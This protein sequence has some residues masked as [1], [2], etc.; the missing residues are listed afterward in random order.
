MARLVRVD[1]TTS[2]IDVARGLAD[3]GAE[4]FTVVLADRQTAGRGRRGCTWMTIPGKSL[5]ATA[6]VR[7]LP[8][9]D[10]LGLAG[11]AAALA[12]VRA[13]RRLHEL[14]LRTKW[15]NDVLAEKRDSPHFLETRHSQRLL[16]KGVCPL[17]CPLF[18]GKV[19]GTLAEVRGS[20]LLLS[21]GLNINGTTAD[22]PS[23]LRATATTLE[24]AVGRPLDRDAVAEG[25]V[26]ELE[27]VWRTLLT[28]PGDLIAE[29]ETLDVTRGRQVTVTDASD[30][31][32]TGRALG[33]DAR[34]CLRLLTAEGEV[35]LSAGDVT[36]TE[37]TQEPG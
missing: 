25:V 14:P 18:P 17:F 3:A 6:I 23:D 33:V 7:E 35:R 29:W 1:E 24:L 28:S 30:G 37:T 11:M 22:L 12:V 36:V 4:H 13:A 2:T 32:L 16:G 8:A 26:A 34:G 19:A 31:T 15:P 5:A 9:R 27:G 21:L 20:A 10:Y